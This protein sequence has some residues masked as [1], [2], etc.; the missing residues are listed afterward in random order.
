MRDFV[1]SGTFRS[2]FQNLEFED[3]LFR[4]SSLDLYKSRPGFNN[5]E[6]S[7]WNS[8]FQTIHDY[9]LYYYDLNAADI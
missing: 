8:K 6:T 1:A 5:T 3:I 2:Q 7:E 9:D 4:V